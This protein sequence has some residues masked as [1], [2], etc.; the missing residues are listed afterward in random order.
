VGERQG[1]LQP[2]RLLRPAPERPEDRRHLYIDLS[3]TYPV[4]ETGFALIGHYGYLDVKH[5][6]SGDL[7]LS[8]SDWKLGASYTVPDGC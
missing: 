2:R 4:G 6:L 5:D 3:A 1:Q 8:Y 7:E